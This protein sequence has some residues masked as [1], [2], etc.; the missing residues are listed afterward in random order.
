M[1]I[2]DPR[3]DVARQPRTEQELTNQRALRDL[4]SKSAS[5]CWT[6]VRK[7]PVVV[8]GVEV[9]GTRYILEVNEPLLHELAAFIAER[10]GTTWDPAAFEHSDLAVAANRGPRRV[11]QHLHPETFELADYLPGGVYAG[12]ELPIHRD[13]EMC[14]MT[15]CTYASSTAEGKAAAEKAVWDARKTI[16]RAAQPA[17]PA[18]V[19]A[20]AQPAEAAV[21]K[22]KKRGTKEQVFGTPE[23]AAAE[24]IRICQELGAPVNEEDVAIIRGRWTAEELEANTLKGLI[25]IAKAAGVKGTSSKSK[26]QLVALLTGTVK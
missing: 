23:E 10:E 14:E 22:T 12:R 3:F 19:K 16:A 17:K 26:T 15:M 6:G 7:N 18:K 20:P 11:K 21:A 1:S 4:R 5:L 25:E 9:T 24:R 13:V 2:N 8:D